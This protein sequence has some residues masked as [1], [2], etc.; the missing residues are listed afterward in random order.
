MY[1]FVEKTCQLYQLLQDQRSKD[2]FWARLAC[3]IEPTEKNIQYL[4]TLGSFKERKLSQVLPKVREFRVMIEDLKIDQKRLI[5]YGTKNTG[6]LIAEAFQ[7]EH[8]DFYGFCGKRFSEFPDGIL[9]KPV[10]SP[11]YLFQN[12]EKFYVV[13]SVTKAKLEIMKLLEE[14]CFPQ[15]HIL[16][17]FDIPWKVEDQY[18]DFPSL[19]HRGTAF[20]D[21]GCYDVY[22]SYRFAEWCKNEY[23]SIF[24][25]E[26]DPDNYSVCIQHLSERSLHN[27]QLI[28]AGVS[29]H[30]GALNF[31]AFGN[32]SSR[33]RDTLEDKGN[34]HL[35]P[36]I[37]T[38]PTVT[39]D[40]IVGEKTVGF[41]KMDIE[42]EEFR[43]LHGAA[44]T[45]TRDKP[46]LAI[47]VYHR[48]GDMLAIMDYLLDLVPDYHF[49]LRH[50]SYSEVE[51]V[52]YASIDFI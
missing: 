12:A 10:I 36:N 6:R 32:G 3:D 28:Q 50:Y 37:I 8:I 39:I 33:V 27:F 49:W 4:A 26:P 31:E 20:V 18:F 23:S 29:D 15:D 14:N 2:I 42:G 13:I 11:E 34:V 51:T 47:C 45:I 25:F 22:T 52:L 40:D 43:A 7:A 44:H 17:C 5:I 9:G 48:K 35:S 41:I 24:A 46:L 21:G 16:Y 30:E 19:F 38:I 1:P